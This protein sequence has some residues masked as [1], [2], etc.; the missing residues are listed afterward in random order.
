MFATSRAFEV[1]HESTAGALRTE[2]DPGGIS[3]FPQIGS[4]LELEIEV[5]SDMIVYE[6]RFLYCFC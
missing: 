5:L 1:P 4:Q 3:A 2:S 6:I